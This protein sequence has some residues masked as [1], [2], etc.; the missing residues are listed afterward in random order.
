MR[1]DMRNDMPKHAGD[2][3][4]Q[5]GRK[6]TRFDTK[7]ARKAAKRRWSKGR[8][9]T[10]SSSG[11][12]TA[13]VVRDPD[14][15]KD[16]LWRKAQEGDIAAARELKAWRGE[17]DGSEGDDPWRTIPREQRDRLLDALAADTHAPAA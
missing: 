1:D 7:T 14:L 16:A 17:G 2:D 15:V 11:A 12:D 6:D 8:E 4:G 5:E 13:P 10:A 3:A 9:G